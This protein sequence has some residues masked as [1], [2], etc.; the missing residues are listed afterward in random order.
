MHRI[1]II[2]LGTYDLPPYSLY[3]NSLTS[4]TVYPSHS[5]RFTILGFRRPNEKG[6]ENRSRVWCFARR[7]E[8]SLV[9][10]TGPLKTYL[11]QAH[12]R[13]TFRTHSRLIRLHCR[14]TETNGLLI[15]L[16][17]QERRRKRKRTIEK[18]VGK[19]D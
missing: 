4:L 13:P 19:A 12:P 3:L 1:I 14:Y 10:L 6:P 7:F 15:R 9:L 16:L 2:S 17:C 8:L 18:A 5:F 11:E